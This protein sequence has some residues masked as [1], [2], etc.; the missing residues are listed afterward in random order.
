MRAAAIFGRTGPRSGGAGVCVA[1]IG[2]HVLGHDIVLPIIAEVVAVQHLGARSCDGS[3]RR[4]VLVDCKYLVLDVGHA[5]PDPTD[6]EVVQ[7][8]ILPAKRYLEHLVQFAERRLRRDMQQPPDA[9]GNVS[10]SHSKCEEV[11][12]GW[13]L[14][15]HACEISATA[16]SFWGLSDPRAAL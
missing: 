15:G 11:S 7:V 5:K 10:E 6:G 3:E 16:P 14:T 9:G 2:F 4:G 12:I 1:T 13:R 8:A